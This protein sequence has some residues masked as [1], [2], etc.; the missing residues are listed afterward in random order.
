M[1]S[2]KYQIGQHATANPSNIQ[3]A[4]YGGKHMYSIQ[5]DSDTD[6]GNLIA[7][8]NWIGLD[9]FDEAE[10][11]A[12]KGEIVQQMPNGNWLVLV[13]SKDD[14]TDACLVY[15]VPVGAEEWTNTWKKE[16][17]LYNPAGTIV[18]CYGLCYHDRFEVS[19]LAFTG[20]PKVGA[21]ITGVAD[22]KMVIAG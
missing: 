5:L 18:R 10:V 9:L 11:T 20:T 16:S 14:E 2:L 7:P 19:D 3:A 4:E 17:N 6:N 8:G 21:K 12:F 1:M 13:T 22:K 15:Q